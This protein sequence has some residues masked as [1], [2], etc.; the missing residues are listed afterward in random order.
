M[1]TLHESGTT[2]SDTKPILLNMFGRHLDNS[3]LDIVRY[4]GLLQ[5]SKYKM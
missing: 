3:C 5:M 4:G 2:L 1:P